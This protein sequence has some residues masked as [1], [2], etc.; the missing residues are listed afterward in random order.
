M[1]EGNVPVGAVVIPTETKAYV[2]N[3]YNKTHR[4]CFA[5]CNFR[6]TGP[7]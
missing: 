2:T 7:F 5:E 3:I 1:N 4:F 6:D